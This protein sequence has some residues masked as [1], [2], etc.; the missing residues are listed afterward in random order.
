MSFLDDADPG[1][2]DGSLG[3]VAVWLNS[4]SVSAV[5]VWLGEGSIVLTS[6]SLVSAADCAPGIPESWVGGPRR[7]VLL[8]AVPCRLVG[9]L[10]A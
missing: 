5:K 3:W 9:V 8:R 6:G 1:P 4:E 10:A 7:L 2:G